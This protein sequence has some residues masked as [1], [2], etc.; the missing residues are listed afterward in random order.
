MTDYTISISRTV[1]TLPWSLSRGVGQVMFQ[2]N[3]WTG[4]LFMIGIFAG[5]YIEGLPVVAW[6]ALTGLFVSTVC[7]YLF[8]LP[9]N[10]GRQGLWGF[11]GVLVGCALPTFL[12]NTVW[13][14]VAL[15]VCSAMT[16]WVRTGM[17]NLLA[18]WRISSFTFP[19]VF[20]TWCFLLAGREFA[21]MAGVHMSQPEIDYTITPIVLHNALDAVEYWLKGVAQVFLIDSWLTGVIFLIALAVAS[22]RAAMWAAISSAV[23]LAMALLW[24]AQGSSIIGGLYGFSAVLTGIALGATFWKPTLRNSL[25]ALF[26]V[27]ATV[28]IQAAMN[29]LLA[30]IGLASLTA[31]FCVATWL[32]MLPKLALDTGSDTSK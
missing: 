14:W 20:C 32:F 22:W 9:K 3:V 16:T 31:P 30:P 5:A 8:G 10:D 26:G 15:V 1:R 28:F 27:V 7:G 17:N 4:V 2:D 25:M 18:P 6:G 21:G 24:E 11:N 29:A 13:M 12:A 23:A 19:F